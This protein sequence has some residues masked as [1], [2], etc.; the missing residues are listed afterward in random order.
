MNARELTQ[1]FFFSTK[2]TTIPIFKRN[3][4]SDKIYN[5]KCRHC[6]TYNYAISSY[7][8]KPY[9][10]VV[11]KHER[12]Y[13][14]EILRTISQT[15]LFTPFQYCTWKL[16]RLWNAASD[17]VWKFRVVRDIFEMFS[18]NSKYFRS[19]FISEHSLSTTSEKAITENIT[20]SI[21]YSVAK[22]MY[23]CFDH[24]W[25]QRFQRENASS[26]DAYLGALFHL[27]TESYGVFFDLCCHENV[28]YL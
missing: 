23:W 11:R 19:P 22:L 25:S 8:R 27:F 26:N 13:T 16:V 2:N 5:E 6:I 4:R 17:V 7:S 12:F 15:V 21:N 9:I 1:L 18:D 28:L 3:I 24:N 10:F 20:R 14:I